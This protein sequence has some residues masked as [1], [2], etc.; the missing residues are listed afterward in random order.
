M[1]DGERCACV[2]AAQRLKA[3]V[4]DYKCFPNDFTSLAADAVEACPPRELAAGGSCHS[5]VLGVASALDG[6]YAA[7]YRV[8]AEKLGRNEFGYGRDLRFTLGRPGA[9]TVPACGYEWS[10]DWDVRK[11]P[12]LKKVGG[13]GGW[14]RPYAD[15][16]TGDLLESYVLPLRR[17]GAVVAV[18][19]AGTFPVASRKPKR[20]AEPDWVAL[21]DPKLKSRLLYANP[22]CLLTTWG[23]ADGAWTRN[24]M[25]ISWL[26]CMNNAGDVLLSLNTRRHSAAAVVS[27]RDFGL[28]IPTAD[29]AAL[30]LAVGGRSGR[31]GP[32]FGAVPGLAAVAPDVAEAPKNGFAA[33]MDDSS[34]DD[35][36]PAASP[37]RPPP[38]F[39]VDG[40]VARLRCRVTATLDGGDDEHHV[41]VAKIE[42]AH[43]REDYW[44]GKTF[45]AESADLPPFLAFLGSQTFGHVSR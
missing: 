11:R 22:V 43:V 6:T 35:D 30:V 20:A 24:A 26:T 15:P 34:D 40:C 41:L 16:V 38:L 5:K 37:D 10:G 9:W 3:A 18:V 39:Y 17:D 45:G 33:L 27:G 25:T 4:L 23:F 13:D 28:S 31:K 1:T 29:L 44:D 12:W 19:V 7:F 36:A 21:P 32:K 14:S 42:D 2:L 8:D